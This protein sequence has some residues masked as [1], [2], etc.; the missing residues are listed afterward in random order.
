M[1]SL[2]TRIGLG[3]FAIFALGM[4]VLTLV[5]SARDSAVATLNSFLN[6]PVVSAQSASAAPEAP[7]PPEAPAVPA[8]P[9][10]AGPHQ[11]VAAAAST[12][13]PFRLEGDRI[14]RISRLAIRRDRAGE[15]PDVNL[16]ITLDRRRDAARL[17]LCTLV[18]SDGQDVAGDAGFECAGSHESSLVTI[19]SARFEPLG[20]SRPI[21]VR[22]SDV[23]DLRQGEPFEATAD[24]DGSVH[25]TARG[26]HGKGLDLTA[27][28]DGAN[29]RISDALGRA[30]VRLL[31]DSSGASL[32]V[33]GKDGREIVSLQAGQG[34]FSL[35]VD[36]A[37]AP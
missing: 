1:R 30:I 35:M 34:G 13:L 14:G 32:R 11:V 15:L 20:F 21:R 2:W 6:T 27:G 10:H 36:S 28:G 8:A 5:R 9:S 31:A 29:L 26:P 24:L 4:L 3:A 7:S 23:A 22:Q 25:V 37:A 18:P 12:A 17:L 33:R 16:T 19:G